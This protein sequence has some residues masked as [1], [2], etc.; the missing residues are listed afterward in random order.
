MENFLH[1]EKSAFIPYIKPCDISATE[2]NSDEQ[3]C[4]N[5]IEIYF[6]MYN[7]KDSYYIKMYKLNKIINILKKYPQL[8]PLLK[9]KIL[10][11]NGLYIVEVFSAEH[12]LDIFLALH[13]ELSKHTS[14][15]LE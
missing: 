11:K 3:I 10:N 1:N 5:S 7:T 8:S 13:I 4:N 6:N 9:K 14:E 2:V 12:F 15:N